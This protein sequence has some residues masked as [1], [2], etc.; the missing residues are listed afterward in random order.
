MYN[1]STLEQIASFICNRNTFIS[2]IKHNK[3]KY[4]KIMILKILEENHM[5]WLF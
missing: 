2:N 1:M 3:K 5:V 4:N